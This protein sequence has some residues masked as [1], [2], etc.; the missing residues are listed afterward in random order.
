MTHRPSCRVVEQART[1]PLEQCPPLAEREQDPSQVG[2]VANVMTAV[3]GDFCARNR[4]A[5]SLVATSQEIKSLVRTRLQGGTLPAESLL[6]QGWRTVHVLPELLA[7]LEGRRTLRIA[8]VGADA[9][10]GYEELKIID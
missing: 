7:M 4:L 3:L 2:L 1:I 8:D 10:F 6:M 5:T 9:P